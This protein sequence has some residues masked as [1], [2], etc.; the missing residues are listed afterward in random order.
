[1]KKENKESAMKVS[2]WSLW[3]IVGARFA[4]SGEW[5]SG[6]LYFWSLTAIWIREPEGPREGAANPDKLLEEPCAGSLSEPHPF[7][8]QYSHA[9]YTLMHA[10]WY[11]FWDARVGRCTLKVHVLMSCR[12]S[13]VRYCL[14]SL[15][16]TI[17][18]SLSTSLC[19]LHSTLKQ[20]KALSDSPIT[21]TRNVSNNLWP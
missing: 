2:M 1:M 8:R 14:L 19:P 16:S 5:V 10:F 15:L 7:F 11:R 21:L 13:S 12:G 9:S 6:A 17:A 3:R 18:A 20:S 4:C